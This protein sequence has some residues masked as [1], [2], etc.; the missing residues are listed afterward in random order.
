M[1]DNQSITFTNMFTS[2]WGIL[3]TIVAIIGL[4]VGVM[5][6]VYKTFPTVGDLNDKAVSIQSTIV[7]KPEY[8]K[9]VI[10]ID[11]K[12][13]K[14]NEQMVK[15]D[16][17][18]KKDLAQEISKLRVEY[19]TERLHDILNQLKL[20][21]EKLLIH[22]EDISLKNFRI[23]LYKEYDRVRSKLDAGLREME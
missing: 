7:P 11:E 20:I 4:G 13:A 19:R 14:L 5:S 1:E 2:V 10:E 18:T 8:Y 23:M 16:A 9:R 21:D 6:F 22:P 3:A 17:Q 12:L 15:S